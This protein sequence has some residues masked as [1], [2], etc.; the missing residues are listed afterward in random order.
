M[1]AKKCGNGGTAIL[2]L[3]LLFCLCLVM[4][5]K[6][7]AASADG[8]TKKSGNYYYYL[9]GKKVKGLQEIEGKTYYFDSKGIRQS[10]WQ[11]I[12]GQWR[13]FKKNGVMARNRSIGRRVIDENG[14]WTPE[15]NGKIIVL[16]PGHSAKMPSGYEPL[17]PGASEMKI[18][19][20][21][22]TQGT[23]TG[24]P[25]YKLTLVIAKK[26]KKELESRGYT[27]LLTRK[28]NNKA[29]SCV[30]RA[31]IANNAKAD[32]Y[33]RLH[34]NGSNDSSVHGALTCCTTLNNPW[35]SKKISRKSA[36]LSKKLLD[37]YVKATGCRKEYIWK[38]D[39]MS[40]NNWSKV[41]TTIIEMGYMTNPAEDRAMQKASYQ[42]KMV[43][44]IADGVD[45]YFG[46]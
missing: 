33:I 7:D 4:P 40:G 13:Y 37:A 21:S 31:K 27:V 5:G 41:P 16:D 29:I 2:F 10:G 23:T 12:K 38:T 14:I 19:D 45:A 11:K 15:D 46:Y 34:A 30:Q 18:K 20:M 9:Q 39:S 17:G 8:W 26:L 43:K 1:R 44:G 6:A 36:K 32:A 35:V 25:E 3:A 42:K 28:S 22:G 24:V